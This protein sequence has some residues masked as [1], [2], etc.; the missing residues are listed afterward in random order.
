VITTATDV[1]GKPAVD[2]LA[3]K[4][5]LRI[6][7]PEAI[8]GVNMAL[9][10]GKQPL[11]YD[12]QNA[13]GR[14]MTPGEA[15]CFEI[16]PTNPW[17]P[18]LGSAASDSPPGVWVHDR[19]QALPGQVLILRPLSLIAG[20]GCNRDTPLGELRE[21]LLKTLAQK[22]LA[23]ESLAGLASI[24]V[25]QDEAGL[26][27]LAGELGLGIRFCSRQEL[28]RIQGIQTPSAMVAKHMGVSSVCEAAALAAAGK[29]QLIVP[30]Q[31]TPNVTVAIARIG[32]MWSES[33]P[34]TRPISRPGL[35]RF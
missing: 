11:L 17:H 31:K 18:A 25:K 3:Q 9:I 32:Y 5:Q 34:E 29:G 22:G 10:E 4:A 13:L 35:A 20:M 12:P 23:R 24:D 7:N 26:L 15:G 14:V 33:G 30:K 8:K 21:L 19:Q 6:V 16:K 1:G 2:T 27:A 28:S